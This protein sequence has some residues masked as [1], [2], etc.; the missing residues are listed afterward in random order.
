MY[1]LDFNILVVEGQSTCKAEIHEIR[2]NYEH[3]QFAFIKL[4]H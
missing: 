4:T 1:C 3:N 2:M